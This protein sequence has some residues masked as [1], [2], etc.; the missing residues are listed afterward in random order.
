MAWLLLSNI[1]SHLWTFLSLTNLANSS[2][3]QNG[4]THMKFPWLWSWVSARV[5]STREEMFSLCQFTGGE[6]Y[7]GQDQDMVPPPC[8]TSGPFPQGQDQDS[9]SPVSS[10]APWVDKPRTEYGAGGTPL[11]FSCRKTFLFDGSTGKRNVLYV[12]SFAR[13]P[14]IRRNQPDSAKHKGY[15]KCSRVQNLSVHS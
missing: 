3:L 9:V 1:T 12:N 5:R 2:S 14:R 10:A 7:P 4:K 13:F 11:V 15:W 6:G 8:S